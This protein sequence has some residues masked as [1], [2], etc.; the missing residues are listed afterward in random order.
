MH[1]HDTTNNA[2]SNCVQASVMTEFQL[3]P[4]KQFGVAAMTLKTWN[5][6]QCQ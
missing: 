5:D 6:R 2:L 4:K 3:A 1:R